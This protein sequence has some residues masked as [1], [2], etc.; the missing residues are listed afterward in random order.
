M[1]IQAHNDP[2]NVLTAV[3]HHATSHL[4]HLL[5]GLYSNI[6]DGIFELAYRS[7][8]QAQQSR[9]FDLMREMR[10]RRSKLIHAFARAMHKAQA[11]WFVNDSGPTRDADATQLARS[12][13]EKSSSHFTH[14]IGCICERV[15]FATDRTV[16]ATDLPIGPQRLA[17]AFVASCHTLNFDNESIEIVRELFGRFVLDR[18]GSIY[19]DCNAR[20]ETAG[21]YTIEE[22]DGVSTTSIA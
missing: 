7:V 17:S 15:G 19:G 20:L 3:H 11:G 2:R 1:N 14:V 13:A 21:Y 6:E 16:K 18:M 4:L 22:L 8:D 10:F 5:D 9:C 12:I